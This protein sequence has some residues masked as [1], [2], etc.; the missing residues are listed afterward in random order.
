MT[1]LNFLKKRLT[2]L[3]GSFKNIKVNYSYEKLAD[4]HL[5]EVSPQSVYDSNEF[6]KWEKNFFT[7]A[8]RE[9]PGDEISFISEDDYL[10]LKHVEWTIQ[11]EEYQDPN[12]ML[13]MTTQDSTENVEEY[14]GANIVAEFEWPDNIECSSISYDFES[15]HVDQPKQL[16][17]DYGYNNESSTLHDEYL[18]QAA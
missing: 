11:G 15:F 13:E 8:L 14:S 9:F 1:I 6:V 2:D 3:V 5:V 10:G 17:K 18:P 4:I 16:C 12:C 7:Q